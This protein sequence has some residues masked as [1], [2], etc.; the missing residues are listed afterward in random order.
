MSSA[1]RVFQPLAVVG[2]LFFTMGVAFGTAAVYRGGPGAPSTALRAAAHRPG[3]LGATGP[4]TTPTASPTATSDDRPTPAVTSTE[5]A[6]PM[7]SETPMPTETTPPTPTETPTPTDT[8][9][10]TLTAT[11]TPT[12]TPT[13]TATRT[14]HPAYLPMMLREPACVPEGRYSDVVFVV[15]VSN[16]MRNVINGKL[17]TDW[18]K[19]WM[20]QTVDR[21]DMTHAKLGIVQ[22]NR[23]VVV[24]QAL[25]NDRQAVL[26]G[27]EAEPAHKSGI[28]RMD[29]ALLIAR[30]LLAG[31]GATPGNARA[32]F[33]ISLMQANG[34]P[35]KYV[36][37][38]DS[39]ECVVLRAADEVKHASVP[40]TIYALAI[41][42]Y[43]NGHLKGVASD[44]DKVYLLPGE[45]EWNKIY[46]ELLPARICPADM[47]WPRAKP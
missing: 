33:F 29:I 16:Y 34:V 3:A 41:S 8:A 12:Q 13:P 21:L 43:G 38:C 24:V 20:R 28:T 36:P 25:T 11:P 37:G 23:D 17:S 9:T 14:P 39:P 46:A 26:D 31:D 40:I 45:A 15:D 47:Y 10:P 2:L 44:P 19:D 22:F 7:P 27:I 1:I 18:A 32:I 30:N 6:Q 4:Y 35:F 5:T 42:W